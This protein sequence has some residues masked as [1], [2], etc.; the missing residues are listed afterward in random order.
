MTLRS[1]LRVPGRHG[2]RDSVSREQHKAVCDERDWLRG[3]LAARA[4]ARPE[5]VPTILRA[6]A[7]MPDPGGQAVTLDIS[8]EQVIC[9]LGDEPGGTPFSWWA[10]ARRL[11]AEQIAS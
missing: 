11:A 8:G 5:D 9:V 2:P 4:C 6:A 3:A 10:A 1:F 7:A